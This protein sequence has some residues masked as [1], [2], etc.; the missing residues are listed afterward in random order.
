MFGVNKTPLNLLAVRLAPLGLI[1]TGMT[2]LRK[3]HLPTGDHL[4]ESRIRNQVTRR[5]QTSSQVHL[6][7]RYQSRPRPP[8]VARVSIGT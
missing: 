5:P 7:P 3:V 4:A 6:P 8:L 2:P 1:G